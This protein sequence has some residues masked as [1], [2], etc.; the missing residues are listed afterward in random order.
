MHFF[1]KL[2]RALLFFPLVVLLLFEEWGWTP[3]A[4]GIAAVARLPWWAQLERLI[5]NLSPW[6][7]LFTFGVPVLALVPVKLLAL[8]LFGKGDITLGLTL[9]IGAK[10]LGT[11]VAARLFQLTEPA[12]MKLKFFARLYVPWKIWKDKVLTQVRNSGLWRR[13]RGL[14]TRV[15]QT[16][17]RFWKI[18]SAA[19]RP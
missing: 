9:L 13:C 19:F 1:K 18:C 11:A 16:S 17:R 12:L 10:I 7:A 14:K 4:K 6:A 8:Y 5:S 3:L 2:L 15:K